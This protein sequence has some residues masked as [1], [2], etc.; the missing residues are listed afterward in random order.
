MFVVSAVVWY[1]TDDEPREGDLEQADCEVA[2]HG[3]SA[4]GLVRVDTVRDGLSDGFPESEDTTVSSV[5]L[6]VPCEAR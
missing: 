2:P 6:D 5:R 4:E 1:H 3:S